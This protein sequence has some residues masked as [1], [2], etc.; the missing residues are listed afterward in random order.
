MGQVP[1]SERLHFNY[2][3]ILRGL[4]LLGQEHAHLVPQT[5]HYENEDCL[6]M[7]L[8][9]HVFFCSFL[10]T[11]FFTNQVPRAWILF[12]FLPEVQT[13]YLADPKNTS[14]LFS[15]PLFISGLPIS[16]TNNGDKSVSQL[17]IL[18]SNPKGGD[19]ETQIL[20]AQSFF[21]LFSPWFLSFSMNTK[22]FSFFPP[23]L[24]HVPTVAI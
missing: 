3:K 16:L 7:C 14:F 9:L 8:F 15:P 2:S 22:S 10:S 21:C 11:H 1:W 5:G 18:S 12:F 19:G 23:H 20:H 4:V 24:F 6:S 17:S 13:L